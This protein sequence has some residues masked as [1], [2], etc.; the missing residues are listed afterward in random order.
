[1][2]PSAARRVA[3]A[4]PRCRAS[5]SWAFIRARATPRRER[6]FAPTTREMRFVRELVETSVGAYLQIDGPDFSLTLE[7]DH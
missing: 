5:S 3:I 2:P 6:D 4:T 1:M 7:G